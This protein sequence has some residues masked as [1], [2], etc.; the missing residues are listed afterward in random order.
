MQEVSTKPATSTAEDKMHVQ[1]LS[2]REFYLIAD[3]KQ[4]EGSS[5]KPFDC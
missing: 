3:T 1:H 5:E 2:L 4:I